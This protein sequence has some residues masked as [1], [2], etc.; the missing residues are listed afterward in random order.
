[1]K[2]TLFATILAAAGLAGA[3]ALAQHSGHEQH[4]AAAAAADTV[5]G[6]I[7]KVDKTARKITLQHGELKNLGMGAMTMAF[8]VK[9]ASLLDKARQG[10]KVRFTLEKLDGALTVT[11]LDAVN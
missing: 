6:V 7:K 3:P 8:R 10:D 9:D 4:D 1:M 2:A 11:S 5:E